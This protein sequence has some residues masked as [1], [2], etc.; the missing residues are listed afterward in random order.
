MPRKGW[1][2]PATLVLMALPPPPGLSHQGQLVLVMSLMAT[3]LFVT[4][5][6]PLPTV[7]L[8][9][10][11]GE[12]V[13]LDP[14]LAGELHVGRADEREIALIGNCEADAPVGILQGVRRTMRE[15]ALDWAGNQAGLTGQRGGC[16][17][18]ASDASSL[19]GRTS[20]PFDS[21]PVRRRWPDLAL[22]AP[23]GNR[24]RLVHEQQ[25]RATVEPR[26][27]LPFAHANG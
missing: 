26:V 11:V 13:L 19:L 22:A 7:P 5:A 18:T 10:I 4:E 14:Q 3:M 1:G 8:L 12:V 25:L 24:R 15:A 6:I 21:G 9:I 27:L 20:C 16:P 2:V 23:L 17:S